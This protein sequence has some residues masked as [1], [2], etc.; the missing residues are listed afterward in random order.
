MDEALEQYRIALS[1]DPLSSIIGANYALVA[2]G[3]RVIP[4]PRQFQKVLARDPNFP[5]AHYSYRQLYAATGRFPEA[6]SEMRKA[7]PIRSRSADAKGYLD[8]AM[9]MTDFDRSS[10]VAVAFCPPECASRPSN[11]W[12]KA[13]ADGDS[14]M[15]FV[16]SPTPPLDPL[17]STPLKDLMRRLGLP[18]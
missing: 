1:L 11:I 8:L 9:A 17:R 13:Y 3:G 12:S 15:L 7:F 18:E 14:E 5:P 16:I 4:V 2:H 6:V 10:A